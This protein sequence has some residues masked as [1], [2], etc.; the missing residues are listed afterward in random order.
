MP[1]EFS[2]LI[3]SDYLSSFVQIFN[4]L[5]KN[6]CLFIPIVIYNNLST[7]INRKI[8]IKDNEGKSGIYRWTNIKNGKSYI[9]S[10]SK[11]NKRFLNYFNYNYLID[12]NKNM[13]INKSLLKNG[14]F[15]LEILE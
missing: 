13:L 10:S 7:D 1:L 2:F 3:H 14:S 5:D 15:K 6:F 8:I 4:N 9:G 12:P 11:L